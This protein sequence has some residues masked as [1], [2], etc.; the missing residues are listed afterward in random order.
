MAL[1]AVA[2]ADSIVKLF[3]TCVNLFGVVIV[4]TTERRGTLWVEE[5]ELPYHSTRQWINGSATVEL[6]EA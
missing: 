6:V 2:F 3:S 4:A 5:Q 1:R